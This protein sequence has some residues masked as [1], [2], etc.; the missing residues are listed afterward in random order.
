[1][2]QFQLTVTDLNERVFLE[3]AL[4]WYREMRTVC[5]EAPD[6]CVLSQAEQVALQGGRELV[7]HG[8]EAVLNEQAREAEKKGRRRGRVPAAKPIAGIADAARGST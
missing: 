5:R 2:T 1:M 6:G 4:A 8:F 7:R 3:Q